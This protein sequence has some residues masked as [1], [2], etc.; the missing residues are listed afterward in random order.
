MS[1]YGLISEYVE[2]RA[3]LADEALD[4]LNGLVATNCRRYKAM[5]TAVAALSR[6]VTRP[7][8]S[9]EARQMIW[10]QVL[11]LGRANE[12]RVGDRDL[13]ELNLLIERGRHDLELAPP[14]K[15]EFAEDGGTK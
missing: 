3:A 2:R 4:K 1:R 12:T 14:T 15:L 9:D 6:V 7:D 11:Q 13:I 5:L 10:A 8:I